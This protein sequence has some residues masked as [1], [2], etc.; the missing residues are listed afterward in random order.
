ML[1][2]TVLTLTLFVAKSLLEGN[3]WEV[4]WPMVALMGMGQA[5]YLAPKLRSEEAAPPAA[6]PGGAGR[7]EGA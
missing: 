3:L 4:P 7:A 1:F 2:W 6:P 5:G